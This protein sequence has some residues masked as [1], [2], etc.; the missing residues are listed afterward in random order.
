[1]HSTSWSTVEQLVEIFQLVDQLLIN[2][3]ELIQLVDQL[4]INFLEL[5]QLVEQLLI[6]LLILQ[7]WFMLINSWSTVDSFRIQPC[8]STVDQ[9]L[10]GWDLKLTQSWSTVDQ[11]ISNRVESIQLPGQ[12]LI[13]CWSTWVQ[14]SVRKFLGVKGCANVHVVSEPTWV[15]S[16]P[17]QSISHLIAEANFARGPKSATPIW[18]PKASRH[19]LCPGPGPKPPKCKSYEAQGLA[20]GPR[21]RARSGAGFNVAA[22]PWGLKKLE[23]I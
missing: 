6:N 20:R 21:P 2:F 5:F 18:A 1:M 12:Q 23:R 11:L 8:W 19:A 13:N 4:L 10:P 7:S 16:E 17:K 9:L 22:A 14:L 3:V 15:L